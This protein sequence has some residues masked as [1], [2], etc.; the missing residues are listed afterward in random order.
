LPN[1]ADR[2]KAGIRSQVEKPFHIVNNV[3]G[4]KK[5]RNG[6]LAKNSAQPH[7]LFAL[8]NLMIAKRRL[9]ELRA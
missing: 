1:A 7:T 6:E 2:V 8:V 5:M 9:F 4:H 3:F